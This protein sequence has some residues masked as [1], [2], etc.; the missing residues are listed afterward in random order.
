MLDVSKSQFS[1]LI[2]Q[3]VPLFTDKATFF[4]CKADLLIM[5]NKAFADT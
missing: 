4:Y 5:H 1:V 3:T 2:L